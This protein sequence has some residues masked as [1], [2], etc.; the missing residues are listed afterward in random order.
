MVEAPRIPSP[1]LGVVHRLAQRA[2]VDAVMLA[3][4]R[5]FRSDHRARQIRRHRRKIDPLP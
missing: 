3:E 2:P 5:I 1:F 4:M